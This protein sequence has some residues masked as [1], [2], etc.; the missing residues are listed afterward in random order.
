M[1]FKSPAH[2]DDSPE[3]LL[4]QLGPGQRALLARAAELAA[5]QGSM[6][7]LVGGVV[8]DLLLGLP[9]ERDLDLAVEGDV[10]GLAAP[11]A[12]LPGGRLVAQHPPFA[13]ATVEVELGG[14][15]V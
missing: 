9:L 3:Q 10:A 6:L 8:R 4:A 11:L 2:S 14:Q 5:G 7:W 15:S 1:M 13:T 12:A